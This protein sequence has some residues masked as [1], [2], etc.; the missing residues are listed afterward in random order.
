MIKEYWIVQDFHTNGHV[1]PQLRCT[2]CLDAIARIRAFTAK[3]TDLGLV[4]RV[5]VPA[6]ATDEERHQIREVGATVI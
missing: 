4:I 3:N 6:T 2:S 1:G 5:H